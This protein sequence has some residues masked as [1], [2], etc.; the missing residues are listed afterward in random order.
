MAAGQGTVG[1]GPGTVAANPGAEARPYG[2]GPE[3]RPRRARDRGQAAI[4]FIGFVPILLLVAFAAIQ[5]GVVAYAA[6]QAGTAARAA[7]R[8]DAYE[9]A[10]TD[11]AA[12][13]RSAI[14]GWLA[15][16]ATVSVGGGED[17]SVATAGITIPS[18]IPG[19]DNFGTVERSA[20]MPRD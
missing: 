10:D 14:S 5:L 8:T 15:D 6:S 19:I 2:G 4:E 12:A 1:A 13:G 16:G 18:V 11:P 20:T 9:E 17:E 3:R 7:A